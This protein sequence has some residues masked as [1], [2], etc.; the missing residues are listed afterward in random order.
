MMTQLLAVLKSHPGTA[1]LAGTPLVVLIIAGIW[2]L[3]RRPLTPEEIEQRRRLHVSRTGRAIEGWLIDEDGRH[4]HFTY[5]VSGVQY[6]AMQDISTLLAQLPDEISRM[7]GAISVK[8]ERGSPENSIVL[9]EEWSGL[10]VRAQ[11][12]AEVQSA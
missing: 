10:P 11:A 5:T 2:W 12:R 3:R 6:Q 8:Y 7:V 9:S 1:A 4:L